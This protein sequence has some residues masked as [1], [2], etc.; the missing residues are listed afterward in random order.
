[1]PIMIGRSTAVHV[2]LGVV[3]SSSLI[4][5][6]TFTVTNPN[7]S[8][9]GSLRQAILDAN[10]NAGD[11][12]ISFNILGSGVQTIAPASA[13]PAITESVT[14]DG[15]TQP[16]AS[17][18]TNAP[19]QGT[20]A[21]ILIE[22]D[23]TNTGSA[24]GDSI[25]KILGTVGGTIRG[26]AVNRG[27][28]GGI[29]IDSSSNV[30]VEGCFISTD[31]TGSI[32]LANHNFGISLL[33]ATDATIGGSTAAA[34]NVISGT[35]GDAVYISGG[36]GHVV[37]GNLIGTDAGGTLALSPD[38]AGV[39][40]VL[41]AVEMRVGGTTPAERNV[42]AGN[43]Y[44]VL[45]HDPVSDSIVE[46][47][48]IGTDVTG[49][50]PLGNAI[51]GVSVVGPNTIGGSTAGAGNVLSG[52]VNSGLII[53][54]AGAIVQGNRIG[55]AADGISP[56]GNVGRGILVLG[57]DGDVLVG[58]TGAGEGNTIAFNGLQGVDVY[59]LTVA[60]TTGT[61]IRG[62][63]IHGNGT[64]GI[65][66]NDDGVSPNDI[67]DAHLFS[68]GTQNYPIIALVSP[69]ASST[70]VEGTLDSRAS[71]TFDVD[72]YAGPT[73]LN[74]PQEFLEGEQYLGSTPVTTDASG[75]GSFSV[76]VPFVLAPGQP[77]TATAT[78]PDGSTSEFSQRIV[79]TS[80]PSSGPPPAASPCRSAACSSKTA[81]RS[82]SV[83]CAATN[84]VLV[85]AYLIEANSPALSAG[86]L[87]DV[88]VTDPSG[89]SGTLRN[90]YVADFLDAPGNP[91][92]YLY[93]TRLV[94]NEI[95]VGIG[96]GLYGVDQ[97]TL[98]QQMAVFLLKAIHGLCYTPPPCKGIFGDV[99]CPSLFADWIE[100]MANEGI[101]GGCGNG[102]YCP[103]S[104]VRRDQMAVF[105]LKG[106][107]GSGY[108]PPACQS[109]FGDVPCPSQFADW[110]EQLYAENITG[111]CGTSPLIYCPSDPNMRGQMAVFLV[112]TFNLQ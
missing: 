92:F 100:A 58:G 90:A 107:H 46:G 82:R 81:S 8:G 84:V 42:I 39:E 56:M 3:L 28:I 15:N 43:Y 70:N 23:G 54:S 91:Q 64:I 104:P 111:G 4:S 14:I 67:G 11:D 102:N 52:N 101:T 31:P 53:T 33:D 20:N 66:L 38:Q 88:V 36:S 61:T 47:N 105:L 73:C 48:Y 98:R 109:V 2:V 19:D 21:V 110:V 41:S 12:T 112:K 97:P 5:G 108:V 37:S 103:Q 6:A 94:S 83:G 32:A 65:D 89:L 1:M 72:F 76:D 9:A 50:V 96:G 69:G 18:N 57:V 80:T 13:L 40:L 71:M 60:T 87:N 25:L 16:G 85:D 29:L 95:T 75:H 35:V 45:L 68:N 99:A 22:I 86:T 49:A 24:S 63:A 17:A 55:T 10:A 27:P 34:R 77:V 30:R 59:N 26:L 7:D 79:L 106:E 78:A 62:N 74:R 93:V 44:G 51:H